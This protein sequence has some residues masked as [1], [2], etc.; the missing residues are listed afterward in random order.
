MQIKQF[1]RNFKKCKTKTQY[2]L[3]LAFFGLMASGVYAQRPVTGTVRDAADDSTLPG[4]TILIKGTTTGT[5]SDFN[6]NFTINVTDEESILVFSFVGYRQVET[7]VQGKQELTISLMPLISQLEEFVVVGYSSQKKKD[8]TGAVSVVQTE[9][10]D[11]NISANAMQSI[12]GQVPGMLI[13]SDGSPDGSVDIKI[14]G[15]NSINSNTAPL[16]IVDGVPTT[17][18]L[19]ELNAM[20]IESMQVLKDASA[21]SIYGSR[22][23]NGVIIITTKKGEKGKTKVNLKANSGLSFYA[24]RPEVL[25]S[26]QYGQAYWQA[27]VNDGTDPNRHY[28]YKYNWHL[29][30]NGKAVLDDILLPRYLDAEKTMLTANTD[31]YNEISR[32]GLQQ[33]VDL[34]LSQGT[35]KSSSMFSIGLFDNQGIINTSR[36]SRLNARLNSDYKMLNNRLTVGENL[37]FSYLRETTTDVLNLTLQTLPVI[38]VRTI[39]GIGWGGPVA[40]MNDRQNP[41]RI[42]ED[43][44][45]N[46]SNFLRIFGNVFLD[47]EI[48][49][50]VKFRSSM[51]IDYGNYYRKDMAL[52]YQSGYLNNQTNKVSN[53]QSHTFKY[54]W[55]NTLN[56]D[57]NLGKNDFSFLLGSEMFSDSYQDFGASVENFELEDPD[58]MYLN[59]GTGTKAVSGSGTGY[60]LLSYFGK[61]NYTYNNKYLASFTMRYDGS[62]RFGSNNQF[63]AFPAASLGWRLSE[64]DFIKENFDYVSDLKLRVG[65]GKTGNQA[66]DNLAR[67]SIY[68]AD[69]NGGNPT[70]A[71]PWGTAYDIG[72]TGGSGLPSG[73]RR[74]RLGNDDLRWETTTQ[75]N[76]GLDFGILNHKIYGSLDYFTKKTKDMLFE[77]GYI[78]VIGEGGNQFVNGATMTNKGLELLLTY[79]G[80]INN[81]WNYTLTGNTATYLNKIVDLPEAV[82]NSYGG[83][84]KGD[85]ILGR[86]IGSF[87]GYVADGIYR[88]E[89]EVANSAE[90]VGKGLGRIRYKDLNGDGVVNDKDRTWIGIPHPDFTYG[91]NMTLKYKDFDMN[92]FWEGVVG[93]D[94]IN[95]AKYHTDFWSVKE[96]GS[97]KGVR[98]LDGWSPLNPDSD[99][100]ALTLIDANNENRFSTYVVESG[101]YLKLRYFQLGYSFNIKTISSEKVRVYIG[102]QNLL[103]IK[104]SSGDNKFTGLDPENPGW[105]YPIPVTLTAGLNISL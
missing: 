3:L 77:P 76:I 57:L 38:P 32:V 102:G 98:L 46:N 25:D 55:S 49:E 17:N 15:I 69:Y 50:N 26:Y 31:W 95:D 19:N 58:Y 24:N 96:S 54:I 84:G 2:L 66:I 42:L 75:T 87:Y 56:Y 43:N 53:F 104:K 72:G 33:S 64:E 34:S 48:A 28:L 10:F 93:L 35:D 68:I 52:S 63:G 37:S 6:G 103:T 51:G 8:L 74:I 9:T 23:S 67:Y 79:N 12:R 40:G 92:M 78:G 44:K 29:D 16:F 91:L 90:S 27:A 62:S 60:R 83:D 101:S 105:G 20:D 85:N 21:A 73:Y 41:A 22:A 65:W 18:N 97:N 13:T 7:P 30:E 45:Q 59:A 100:P 80:R 1:M 99:I 14:R 86:P 47:F 94:V 36:F 39:D 89:D 70:W 71:S 61:A 5:I 4:V 11:R 81:D 82:E 88:T